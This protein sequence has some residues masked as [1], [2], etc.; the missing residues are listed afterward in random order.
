MDALISH[1]TLLSDQAL[2]DR[3]FDPSTIEDLMR[4]FEI[5][6]YKA[7]AALEAEQQQEL[8]DA[9]ESL[10]QAEDCLD[11]EMEMA[12]EEYRRTVEEMERMEAEELREIEEKAERARRGGNLMEKAATAAAKRYMAA[13]MNSAAASMRS[14]W[15]AASG[16]KVHPS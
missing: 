12:M 5:E 15:K 7:W 3:S 4:L 11:R 16:N 8:D 6:S 13:A 14:A 9:E 1:F 2:T 10:R